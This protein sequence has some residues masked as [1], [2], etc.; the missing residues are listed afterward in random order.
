MHPTSLSINQIPTRLR[1]RAQWVCWKYVSRDGRRTKVPINPRYG[2]NAS[3][4]D[5]NSWGGFED[6]VH[7]SEH[8]ETI[9][10]IAFVF[11]ADDPF[12]GI[13]VDD[14]LDEQGKLLWGED[15]LAPLATYTEV[16]PSGRGLKLFLEGKKPDFARCRR[17]GFGPDKQGEVE[18][19][20]HSRVFAV[21]GRVWGTTFDVVN[22]QAE[23]EELCRRLWPQ[24]PKIEQVPTSLDGRLD[25][26]LTAMLKMN[27]ADRNDGSFRLFGVCCRCIEFDLTDT[28]AMQAVRAYEVARPF[29]TKW[30]DPEIAQRLR[31][32]ERTCQRGAALAEPTSATPYIYAPSEAAPCPL[33]IRHLVGG[34]PILRQPVIHGLL[35]QG[36]TLNIISAPKIGKSWLATDLAL[37]VAS[38]RPWLGTYATERGDV[39]C[40]DNEL[41][42]ETSAHRIP[43]VAEAR[44]I[45][46]EE[47]GEH[48]FVENLRGRLKDN[49]SL[50]TYF[51]R[52]EPGRF[53][54]IVLD[55]FYRFM[56]RDTDENDNGAMAH[57]YNYLDAYANRLGCSFVLIHHSSK[58]NQS[59]KAI[60]DVGAGA[61][62]QSR[63][64]DT[65][66]IL[67][68]HEEND[69][70]VLDAAVRSWPPVKPRCLRWTFPVWTPDDSLDP[71]ALRSER[72]RRRA[73]PEGKE[74]A[75]ADWDA[76]QL[77]E[78]LVT[79]EPQ[80]MQAIIVAATKA[81]VSE[82]KAM[83]LLKSA[84]AS[85]V[86]H[87]WRFGNNRP[88]QI[89]T[90][91]QPT[92]A[93]VEVP[94]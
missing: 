77:V 70:V 67:R 38:G 43:K 48:M 90:V 45:P 65:H 37:A 11:S 58:G 14:C 32:A 46:F 57:V 62:S 35:R 20:V 91:A 71:T 83:R 36:E 5:P 85:G 81:G 74:P 16:S 10:G 88:V 19:Y 22:R 55:A 34:Y 40:I 18:G 41:H 64:T 29:P 82:R 47:I 51:E 54:I 73:K 9:E 25:R 6:A 7:Y 87:R 27:I 2:W 31:D 76:Q 63:A 60:T 4:S 66:L 94:F 39:L 86:V 78:A 79:D 59:G 93:G 12:C 49:L 33:S 8:S 21:T 3:V 61:G 28:E 53:R 56:P 42:C 44:G 23:L 75:S 30:T 68:P 15:L 13:D 84:E 52:I 50:S 1:E 26:C 80:P 17:T 24:V 89:A 92:S 72:P 69:C